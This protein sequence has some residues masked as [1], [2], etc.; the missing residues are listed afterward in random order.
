VKNGTDPHSPE[1]NGIAVVDILIKPPRPCVKRG[2][3][4]NLL[5]LRDRKDDGTNARI[6]VYRV[7]IR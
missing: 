2:P 7:I 4:L 6:S 1:V 3:I 5:G